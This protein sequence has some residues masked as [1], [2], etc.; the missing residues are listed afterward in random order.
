MRDQFFYTVDHEWLLASVCVKL[1]LKV[2]G[3]RIYAADLLM[4]V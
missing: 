3:I 4:E 1:P 2:C